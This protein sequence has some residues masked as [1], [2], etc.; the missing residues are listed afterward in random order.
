M[1]ENMLPP[2]AGC[3][4]SPRDRQEAD[5]SSIPPVVGEV[6][7]HSGRTEN[8]QSEMLV[9]PTS[10][11]RSA[12]P[13]LRHLL[14]RR[15]G[16]K[17]SSMADC[18]GARSGMWHRDWTPADNVPKRSRSRRVQCSI[19]WKKRK[20][21]RLAARRGGKASGSGAAPEQ[22]DR[23]RIDV[24]CS[25]HNSFEAPTLF[26]EHRSID[27]G[28]ENQKIPGDGVITGHGTIN[29]RWSYVFSQDFTVFG[30]ALS[31]MHA[32]K[33]CKVMDMAMKGRR[34]CSG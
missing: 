24:P 20:R 2:S 26:V 1:V 23:P 5:T 30:G 29:G 31:A 10:G 4:T 6:P 9:V 34:R 28:M 8:A 25:S 32:A 16:M 13:T 12:P 19:C 21:R 14:R 15:G 33:I 11:A 17:L 7:C 22:A 18:E 27:F 3:A